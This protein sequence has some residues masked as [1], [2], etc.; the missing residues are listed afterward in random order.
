MSYDDHHAEERRASYE[1]GIY[2][3]APLGPG[4]TDPRRGDDPDSIVE[5][6]PGAT[7]PHEQ[8]SVLVDTENAVLVGDM[9]VTAL[10]A[11]RD[12]D[13]TL[14]PV[15]GLQLGGRINKTDEAVRHLYLLNPDGAAALVSEVMGLASRLGPEW[16]KRILE[17]IVDVPK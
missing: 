11:G 16:R 7:D 10:G 14:E 8:D 12:N 9:W 13:P 17:R 3:D 15:I 5:K 6:E 1:A 4:P 2:G